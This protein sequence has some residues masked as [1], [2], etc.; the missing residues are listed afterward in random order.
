MHH[1]CDSSVRQNIAGKVERCSTSQK[2]HGFS[3][4]NAY[5]RTRK[6]TPKPHLMPGTRTAPDAVP[7]HFHSMG[8]YSRQSKEDSVRLLGLQQHQSDIDSAGPWT[9]TGCP[10]NSHPTGGLEVGQMLCSRSPWSS[11]RNVVPHAEHFASCVRVVVI[12]DNQPLLLLRSGA[13]FGSSG[14]LRSAEMPS[15]FRKR[16]TD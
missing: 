10:T 4:E 9:A 11:R 13:S 12:R 3:N 14:G 16:G 15:V 5:Y 1:S 2:R 8:L 7:S 6:P